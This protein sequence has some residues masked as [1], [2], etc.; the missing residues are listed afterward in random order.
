MS[1]IT[2]LLITKVKLHLQLR[3][4]RLM[5]NGSQWGIFSYHLTG[6][7]YCGGAGG[8]RERAT[9]VERYDR[10]WWA[11]YLWCHHQFLRL[12]GISQFTASES[13]DGR[14]WHWLILGGTKNIPDPPDSSAFSLSALVSSLQI[15]QISCL[16]ELWELCDHR[17]TP[18]P[19]H[20]I[21]T[22]IVSGLGFSIIKRGNEV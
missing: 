4:G 14:R 20:P 18:R 7:D 6:N 5:T 21:I 16:W 13:F 11:E 22:I 1:I 17:D 15:N 19:H 12:S 10:M 3:V 9:T 8:G 2:E